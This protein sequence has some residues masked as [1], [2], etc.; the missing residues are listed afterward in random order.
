MTGIAA[1]GNIRLKGRVVDRST[2]KGIGYAILRLEDNSACTSANSEGCFSIS[3]PTGKILLIASS[4][5]FKSDTLKIDTVNNL[6]DPVIYLGKILSQSKTHQNDHDF[7]APELI[8]SIITAK[9]N[10][11][12]TI[13]G[14]QFSAYIR[15]V[16]RENNDVGLGT[17]S[18]G[19]NTGLVKGSFN[20]ISNIWKSKPM[21]IDG[22]DEFTCKGFF[23]RSYSYREIVKDKG[24]RESLPRSLR[25]LLGSRRIQNLSGDDLLFFDRPVPGPVSNGA[26]KYYKYSSAGEQLIDNDRIF[27]ISFRPADIN[28]PGLIG[29]LYVDKRAKRIVKIEAELN[30][31]ANSGNNFKSILL[32]QQYVLYNNHFN[33][34]VD[35]RMLVRTN[36][37][38]IVKVR[39]DYDA[40][41]ENYRINKSDSDYSVNDPA[42]QVVSENSN[43]EPASLEQY[44]PLPFTYEEAEAYERI[45]S[46]RSLPKGFLFKAARIISPQYKISSHF[47]V[48]GPL[49]IYSFNHVEGHTLRFNAA[50]YGLL[51]N[52]LDLR[53]GLSNGFSDKRF[54]ENLTTIFNLNDNHSLKF[55]ADVFN[56]ISTLFLSR[57]GYNSFTT[58][59]FSLLSRHDFSSYYYTQGFSLRTDAAVSRSLGIY[60]EYSNHV[61]HS[62]TT[63]TTFSLLG[64]SRRSFT[65]NN[66]FAFTDSVNPPIYEARLNTVSFGFNFDFRDVVLE[67][68]IRQKISDGRSFVNFGAGIL[69]SSPKYLG[70]DLDFVSYNAD[71]LGEIN[72]FGTSSLGF[73]IT[74]IY[75]KGP[76]PLQMQYALPGNINATGRDFTF[77][78]LG[79]GKMFGDQVLTVSLD[80][81]LRKEIFRVLP[82]PFLRNLSMSSFFNAAWKNMSQRS[83]AIMPIPYQVLTQPLLETGFSLGYSSIPVSLE[84]A[85]RLTH[86]DRSAF[87]VGINTS[88]L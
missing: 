68:N 11:H 38:G 35:Y 20:L 81:N 47:S 76:V 16:I 67:N 27:V 74:G 48:S 69:I 40:L 85:W 33:L 22:I 36:Y 37:L 12:S 7:S 80:Y 65:S 42:L 58:T 54:K 24:P 21:R 4:I 53:I 8:S 26:L 15:C 10:A 14:Y 64:G 25:D 88:I 1:A 73:S 79:I 56:K 31:P 51:D 61:D 60:A 29:K 2:G 46:I 75:S 66:N 9:Q 3:L 84:F 32:S 72:T 34:P 55:S 17:G 82:V 78:T 86:I 63:N 83:A 57:D 41:I 70:S 43:A 19:I 28:N 6:K 30:G 39:Y 50:G 44:R 71:I 13:R 77:R 23:D 5:G 52:T 62:A 18:I 45:D 59:I 49:G 87:R